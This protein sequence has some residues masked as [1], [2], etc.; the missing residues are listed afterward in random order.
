MNLFRGSGRRFNEFAGTNV[1]RVAGISDGIFSVGMT[2]LVLGLSVPALIT[3]RTENDLW[4]ELLG[5]GPNVLVY[6]MSFMTLGIFWV[7]QGT[8]LNLLA[9]SNRNYSWLQLFFLFAVT[10]VPFSTALLARFPTFRVAL[11]AYW[12]NIVLLGMTLLAGLQYGLRAGL[13]KETELPDV[14][15]LMRGRIV[16][17][18]SLYAIATAT[19]FVFPTWVSIGLIFLVQLNYVIAPR[20]PL[21]HR[22]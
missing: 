7:G 10:L 18:Q 14:T 1:D 15:R 12:L 5:L 17:A 11:V 13:F 4:H 22:F 8:Q 21:L 2:L 20:I 6:T 9:R 3:V 19:C 16:I